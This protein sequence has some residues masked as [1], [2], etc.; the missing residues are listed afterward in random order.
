MTTPE[1]TGRAL[2]V[3]VGEAELKWLRFLKPGYRHCFV[4]IEGASGWVVYNPLSHYTE[5]RTYPC[6]DA[7]DIAG[8]Y[9]GIGYEVAETRIHTP[10]K[11]LAPMA[12]FTCV[13]AV[14]R[15]LGIHAR[16]VITPWQLQKHLAN[17]PKN[18]KS[19]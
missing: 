8:F 11:K 12:L 9:R 2:V 17:I 14:K 18:E 6:L 13:E 7:E 1:Y 4:V 15:T 19:P 10:P 16:T 5:I 3:F